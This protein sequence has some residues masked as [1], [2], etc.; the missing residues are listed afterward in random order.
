MSLPSEINLCK[1]VVTDSIKSE[2]LDQVNDDKI[3]NSSEISQEVN[4]LSQEVNNLSQEVN[5]LS[6]EAFNNLSQEVNNLSQE[7]TRLYAVIQEKVKS[8]PTRYIDWSWNKEY[9]ETNIEKLPRES[10]LYDIEYKKDKIT[11][12]KE[13]EMR[14]NGYFNERLNDVS[15]SYHSELLEFRDQHG[16]GLALDK[17]FEYDELYNQFN[18]SINNLKEK[19]YLEFIFERDLH[20]T[21]HAVEKIL[22]VTNLLES[23][24]ERLEGFPQRFIYEFTNPTDYTPREDCVFNSKAC[25]YDYLPK[26]LNDMDLMTIKLNNIFNERLK[27]IPENY[28]SEL[29]ELKD[30]KSVGI[31]LDKL[32]EYDELN[33][34]FNNALNGLPLSYHSQYISKRDEYGTKKALETVLYVKEGLE[35]E[36]DDRL[37]YVPESYRAKLLEIREK[38][39]FPAALSEIYEF[40]DEYP[41]TKEF[42]NSIERDDFYERSGRYDAAI[43]RYKRKHQRR[44]RHKSRK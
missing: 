9:F 44:R 42:L 23:Y 6:Q 17:L 28:H 11:E 12:M 15:E 34:E 40:D 35:S 16:T 18:D 7:A 4:N 29:L 2:L 14:L 32:F 41:P 24:Y 10:I 22:K 33:D 38:K 8:F 19:Y 3:C 30:K 1:V 31:A 5:N 13:L 36:F 26:R 43:D 37:N 25:L 39:G 27:D 21:K 20:G